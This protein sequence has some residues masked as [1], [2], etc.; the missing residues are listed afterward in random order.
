MVPGRLPKGA[1]C[2]PHPRMCKHSDQREQPQESR[3]SS[4]YRQIR[5]LSLCLESQMPTHLL[6]G[7]FQL[8]AHHKPTEDLLWIGIEV[9]TQKGLGFELFLRIAHQDPAQGYGEQA[10]A[11]PHGCFRSDLDHA[12]PAPIPISDLGWLPNGVWVFS[13]HRKVGQALTLEARS[14]SLSGAA[15]KSRFVKGGIQ[16]QAGDEG[17]RP[18]QASA[19]KQQLERG[20]GAVSD[21]HDLALWVPP[22]Y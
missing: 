20:V 12:L 19:M 3:G 18:T 7:Y 15:R 6:E 16:A 17:H 22:P 5:P 2:L 14:P 11:V 9:G 10:R 1:R 21:G 4:S 8:P 13:H